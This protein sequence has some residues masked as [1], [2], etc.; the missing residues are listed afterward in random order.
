MPQ[1]NGVW[2]L[3]AQAQAQSNQ[4]WVT[5]PNFKNTTLLLQADNAANGATNNSFLDS[6]TNGFAITRNGNTTQGSFSPFSQAPGYWGNYLQGSNSGFSFTGINIGTS[7][8][9]FEGWVYV[10]SFGS[11][12]HLYGGSSASDIGIE[13]TN[14]TTI[15]IDQSGVASQSFTVPAMA[16]NAWHHI[17]VVRNASVMTAFVDGVRSSTGTLANTVNYNNFV[18]IGYKSS[19]FALTGYVSNFRVVKA[20]VYDPTQTTIVVPTSPLTS[21]ANTVLLT[22]QSNRF[23]DNGPNAVALTATNSPSVQAF[24]PFAPALQWTPDVVGGSGYFDGSGDYLDAGSNAAFAF[25]TGAYTVEFWVYPTT[26]RNSVFVGNNASG[27]FLF[28]NDTTDGLSLG[29]RGG[30]TLVLSGLGKLIANQWNHIV[31]CR[32]STSSNQASIFANGVRVGNGTD[33]TNWTVTGPCIVGGISSPDYQV[34]GYMCGTR[35]VKGTDVYGYNNTTITIPTTP[36]TAITNTQ[37]LLNYTN[38]G[39]YDG[40]MDNV[41]ETKGNAQVATSPVKFGSGSMYFDGTAAALLPPASNLL[42][43]NTGDFTVE[44]W[45]W[46][47][48]WD[49]NMVVIQ[50]GSN[51]FGIQ[52]YAAGATGNIGVIINGGWVITD[53]FLPLTGQWSHIAVTRTNG[54][55]RFFVNGS[56]TGSSPANTSNISDGIKNIGGEAGQTYFKGYMDDIRVTKGVC[57][58]IANFTPPQQALPRQ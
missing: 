43:F 37:L 17:A 35:I 47:I 24:G 36:P 33:A 25:G 49:S 3:E 55:L 39:I 7:Q 27:G 57:R 38:A 30:A 34:A 31:F 40:A 48:A 51:G 28:Y 15:T 6:S 50:G 26:V 8:F 44:V 53:A 11:I 41:L 10:P 22:C 58:Y 19:G 5:D 9:T 14:A 56:V 16:T 42:A 18:Y 45:V 20:A 29:T 4:Q 2:T 21:I 52:K 54:I 12:Q 1:Y 13:I 23:V 32:S 46:P